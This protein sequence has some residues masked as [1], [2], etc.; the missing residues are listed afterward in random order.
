MEAA[1]EKLGG[2]VYLSI[3]TTELRNQAQAAMQATTAPSASPQPITTPA[4]V[5]EAMVQSIASSG[6]LKGYT[7][8]I[9]SSANANG[10][11]DVTTSQ[12]QNAQQYQQAFQNAQSQMQQQ[13]NA[14]NNAR[15]QFNRQ[16]ASGDSSSSTDSSGD[17]S[18][19]GARTYGGG[20]VGFRMFNF[21][22]NF[23][24]SDPS[25]TRGN[26]TISGTNYF[27]YLADV[28][29]GTLS[30]VTGDDFGASKQVII[31]QAVASANNLTVGD[32][33]N[34]DTT[35]S[36]VSTIS[37][38]ICGI[39]TSSDQNF[40]NNTI[41]MSWDD[42][43]L[44]LD[45]PSNITVSN[46]AFYLT[47]AANKDAFLEEQTS[48]IPSGYTLNVDDT[49]YQTMVG[50]I[51]NVG[52]FAGT[53]M[54]IVISAAVI[55]I[56]LMIAINVKDRRYEMGVL[57]SL[58]AKR[59]NILAQLLVELIIVATIGFALSTISSN[60]IANWASTT[61]LNQQITQTQT[62]QTNNNGPNGARGFTAIMNSNSNAQPIKKIDVN[63]NVTDYLILFGSGYLI[64]LISLIIPSL[65]VLRLQPKTI[66]TGKE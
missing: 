66:L 44:F 20:G 54:W 27:A 14:F 26:M 13:Q 10:F 61:L 65:N 11:N 31:S 43:K 33:I 40:D 56:T 24:L 1:K 22:L 2:V 45:D 37:F 8:T 53:I 41:Y 34:L 32:T 25:L 7:Y 17:G 58:G 19:G 3:D 21:S 29:A 59:K 28:Q 12:N 23:N 50:P 4:P 39:Y 9:G 49:A 35:G 16:G 48:N 30:L 57:M 60:Y 47:S 51:Q 62:E 15:S 64:I 38:T 63:P 18:A 46:V 36:T 6:Y 55:I 5:T 52:S 42:A